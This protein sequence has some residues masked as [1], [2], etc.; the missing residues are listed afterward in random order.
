MTDE[1][2]N[3]ETVVLSRRDRRQAGVDQPDE[4]TVVV[5]RSVRG[6]RRTRGDA[7][8]TNAENPDE[9]AAPPRVAPFAPPHSGA[10]PLIYKPRPAPL[11]P[12]DPP[13]V[14]GAAAPT[15]TE[16]QNLPSVVKQGQ[17]WSVIALAAAAS[18]C[19]VSV[20]GLVMLGFFVLV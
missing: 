13:I 12:V 7:E 16:D 3:E 18:A 8:S 9:S 20:L 5:S 17:R 11:E 4:A 6:L 15:R 2:E 19:V 10:T 1:N 14:V